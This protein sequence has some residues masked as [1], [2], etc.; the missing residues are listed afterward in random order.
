MYHIP[1]EE[2]TAIITGVNGQDGSYLAELLLDKGYHVVGIVRRSSVDNTERIVGI[3][4]HPHFELVE[5]DITDATS[6]NSWLMK[7]KPEEFYNL[8]AQS[9]VGTSF[10]QPV[11]TWRVDAEAVINILEGIRNHSQDTK[12]YQASTSEM[13]GKNFSVPEGYSQDH[14]LPSDL[15]KWQDE[16]TPFSP[17]SPYGVAKVAAHYAVDMYREAYG[18]HASCGILFNHESER[19]GD[20]FVTRKITKWLGKYH[21]WVV[22]LEGNFDRNHVMSDGANH[23]EPYLETIVWDSGVSF[24]KLRLGNLEAKRD[25][26]HAEDYVKGMWLMLQQDTP[27]DYVLATGQAYSVEDF[28]VE[29]FKSVGIDDYKMYVVQDPKFMRPAEVDFLLGEADKAKTVL[30]WEPQVSF[31]ELV[32]RMVNNDVKEKLQ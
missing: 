27:D 6:V 19:R 28:L 8:A 29:A 4:K 15:Y 7:Y 22:H 2:R 25:W 5:G 11:L 9:H 20:E 26:G 13:F 10:K 21:K 30:G 23:R 24:P 18:L 32:T 14:V 17:Q 12:F 16:D 1:M 3:I 31:K